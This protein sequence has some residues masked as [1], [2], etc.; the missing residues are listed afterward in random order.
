MEVTIRETVY[1]SNGVNEYIVRQD[2]SGVERGQLVFFYDA[3]K[4]VA[5]GFNKDFCVEQQS[6]F[7]VKRVITDREVSVKQVIRLIDNFTPE[8]LTHPEGLRYLKEQITS[9]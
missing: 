6:M 3:T 1:V 7:R 4:T 8:M 2:T 9:L 5:I